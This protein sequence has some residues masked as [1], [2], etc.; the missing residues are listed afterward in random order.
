MISGIDVNFNDETHVLSINGKKHAVGDPGEIDAL[1][2]RVTALA[3]EESISGSG[4]FSCTYTA[5]KKGRIVQL[6]VQNVVNAQTSQLMT[7]FN[8]PAGWRPV[9]DI[10]ANG[11]YNR[12][13][14]DLSGGNSVGFRIETGGKVVTYSYSAFVAGNFDIIYISES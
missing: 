2:E 5:F 4:A 3:A 1:D 13:S 8:L 12:G 10:D 9:M 11:K 7:L 14:F 6:S